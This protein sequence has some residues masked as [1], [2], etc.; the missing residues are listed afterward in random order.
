MS[1]YEFDNISDYLQAIYEFKKAK[2]PQFS[3]RA[4]SDQLGFSSSGAFNQMLKKKRPFPKN[5]IKKIS[6]LLSL[7][8]QETNYLKGHQRLVTTT[9]IENFKIADIHKYYLPRMDGHC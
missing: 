8:D 2:N 1:I 7:S 9:D 6:V 3:L 5:S 4:L